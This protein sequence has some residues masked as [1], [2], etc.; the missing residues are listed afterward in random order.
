MWGPPPRLT[1]AQITSNLHAAKSP[2]LTSERP[3]A[4]TCPFT[5][6]LKGLF[7]PLALYSTPI[8]LPQPPS[9]LLALLWRKFCKAQSYSPFFFLL[10]P[11]C[12]RPLRA[13]VSPEC[14]SAHP[15]A[16][17]TRHLFP[18]LN[19]TQPNGQCPALLTAT[20]FSRLFPGAWKPFSVLTVRKHSAPL[21]FLTSRGRLTPLVTSSTSSDMLLL[22]HFL[23]FSTAIVFFSKVMLCWVRAKTEPLKNICPNLK[24]IRITLR[25]HQ[26]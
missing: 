25:W 5:S 22:V 18:R 21:P 15:C 20:K 9:A 13:A 7:Y 8:C 4:S 19:T 2:V 16:V 6:F 11:L 10:C 3:L 1:D 23:K 17:F 24:L 12:R 14:L 26:G